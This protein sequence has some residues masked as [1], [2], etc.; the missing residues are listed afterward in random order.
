MVEV[1]VRGLAAVLTD[2]GCVCV[3]CRSRFGLFACVVS[4]SIRYPCISHCIFGI[5][6]EPCPS[7]I[8]STRTF[9]R[10]YSTFMIHTL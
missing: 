3:G 4:S 2:R 8:C 5:L 10:I 7:A 6:I 1:G 9:A